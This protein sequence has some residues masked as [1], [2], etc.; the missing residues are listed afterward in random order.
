MTENEREYY[1]ERVAIC[2]ESGVP[3]H[4]ARAI[5]ARQIERMRRNPPWNK[6]LMG[7]GK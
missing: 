2:I 5:A 1:E 6:H 3:E 7:G 4:G